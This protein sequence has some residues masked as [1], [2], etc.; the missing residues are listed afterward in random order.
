M[1]E[2]WQEFRDRMDMRHGFETWICQALHLAQVAARRILFLHAFPSKITNIFRDARLGK[3]L[4]MIDV[5]GH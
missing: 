5:S 2:V 4:D 1:H 3:N